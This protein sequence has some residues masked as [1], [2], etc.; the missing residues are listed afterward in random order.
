MPYGLRK[1]GKKYQ[2]IKKSDGKVMGTHPSKAAATAQIRALYA[3]S[4]E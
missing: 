1:K 4:K 3:N 2:V